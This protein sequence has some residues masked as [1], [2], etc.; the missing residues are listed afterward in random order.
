MLYT[1]ATI[2][3]MLHGP[4]PIAYQASAMHKVLTH[5]QNHLQISRSKLMHVYA[6]D[7]NE[8]KLWYP[9]EDVLT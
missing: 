9:T 5:V 6:V 7:D 8:A 3:G 4:I 2:H 1:L